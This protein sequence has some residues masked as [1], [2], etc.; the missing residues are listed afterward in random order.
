MLVDHHCLPRPAPSCPMCGERL[1][2]P[3]HCGI[4][5]ADITPAHVCQPHP[6]PHVCGTPPTPGRCVAC[7]ES[8]PARQFC[9]TCGADIT[10]SHRCRAAPPTQ[11]PRPDPIHR[12]PALELPR[13]PACGALL[14]AMQF[15]VRCGV[16]ITPVHT[17]A[18]Q[19]AAHICPPVVTMPRRCPSCGEIKPASQHCTQCGAD[20]TPEHV[21]VAA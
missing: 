8:Y 17:C 18:R 19:Q 5:G 21:C 7:G 20:I 3:V 9:A 16:E 2:A 15:C 13:C 10:P 14:P 12:C 11:V 4:C 1:S 6:L